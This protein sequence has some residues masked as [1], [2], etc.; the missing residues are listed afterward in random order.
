MI[1][2]LAWNINNASTSSDNTITFILA[3]TTPPSISSPS[4]SSG[5]L[6]PWWNHN[7]VI[8]Y[9]DTESAIDA[10][11]ANIILNKWDW[12]S[13]WGADISAAW[14]NTVS[15]ST[16]SA[17]YNTNNLS[18]WKYR[19]TFFIND[20]AWNTGVWERVFYIDQPE[21]V[22]WSW[23]IDMWYVDSIW[24]DF[25]D[26]VTITVLTVGAPF[27]LTFTNTTLPSYVPESIPA[28]NG[29]TGLGYQQSPFS[30]TLSV[31]NSNETIASE[32]LLI[33]TNGNKNTYTYN[34]QIGALIDI[35]QT[36]GEYIWDLKFDIDLQY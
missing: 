2:D 33:N 11:T 18:F 26:T 32:A 1:E 16:S 17:S 8:N 6:L 31:I 34:I 27:D 3:D 14:L 29:T 4:F 21:L 9:T 13:A 28:W 30:W 20:S 25:S 10:G 24:A 15:I 35:A 22:V 12:I 5:A 7:I 23:S 19:Y 36:A